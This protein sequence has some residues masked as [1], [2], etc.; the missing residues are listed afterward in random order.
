MRIIELLPFS[1]ESAAG[2][3]NCNFLFKE[4]ICIL[5]LPLHSVIGC[6]QAPTDDK[7]INWESMPQVQSASFTGASIA[8][9]M[10][11]RKG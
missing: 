3:P 8:S 4:Y 7:A 6:S 10:T 11:L 1:A 5:S 9:F 2:P